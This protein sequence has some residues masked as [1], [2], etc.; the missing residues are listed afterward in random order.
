MFKVK[1]IYNILTFFKHKN[2]KYV[3]NMIILELLS[4]EIVALVGQNLFKMYIVNLEWKITL[5][6]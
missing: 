4:R 5:L 6:N 1:V 3:Y 2:M